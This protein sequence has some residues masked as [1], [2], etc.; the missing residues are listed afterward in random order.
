MRQSYN[1]L[2]YMLLLPIV[3]VAHNGNKF[4]GKYTK[5]KKIT[6]EYTV[7]PNAGLRVNNRYG[8]IDIVTW[9]E[10]K[11]V[12]DV[13][14]KT[15]GDDEEAVKEKLNEITIDF[16]GDT[17]LITAKTILGQ[18]KSSSWQGISSF[19]SGGNKNAISMEINYIIKIPITNTVDLNNSYG[20][21]NIDRLEGNAKINCDYCQL[22]IGDLLADNNYL[23]FD[24]T[25]NSSIN[26]MKSGKIT[27]DY[28]SFILEKA[29]SLELNADYSKT[30]INDVQ[31]LSYNCDYGRII[32]ANADSIIG[33]GDHITNKIGTVNS[34]ININT[35]YSSISIKRLTKNVKEVIIKSE[36]TGISLGLD[37]M[38]HFNF[39]VDL[40]YASFKGNEH[41]SV[42]K[43]TKDYTDKYYEGYHGT[44]NSGNQMS[45]SS[46]Y[47]GVKFIKL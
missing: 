15:N 43:T 11:T 34:S 36:Y 22:I 32:L 40:E 29:E 26:Y 13:I 23:N 20:T 14:I 35:D 24:Y 19:F 7:N 30:E 2:I 38:Y 1:A 41:V 10:N 46:Q 31:K 42:T 47:G 27:A 4:K 18:R 8:N 3:M 44:N 45:I 37:P 28:S 17:S 21:I 9:N 39:I 12:I 5:E 25:D 33:R 16:S 6:K